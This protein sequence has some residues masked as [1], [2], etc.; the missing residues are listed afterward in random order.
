MWCCWISS[1]HNPKRHW[2]VLEFR[3]IG[4]NGGVR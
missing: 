4:E 2:F 3:A 1:G